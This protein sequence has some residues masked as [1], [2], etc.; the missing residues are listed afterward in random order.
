MTA[1]TISERQDLRRV[2]SEGCDV[3]DPTWARRLLQLARHVP[4]Y[5]VTSEGDHP[6]ALFHVELTPEGVEAAGLTPVRNLLG[7]V[8]DRLTMY[9]AVY[10]G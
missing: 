3:F 5:L 9:T 7:N 1:L 6:D 10:G 2:G 8:L 4:E